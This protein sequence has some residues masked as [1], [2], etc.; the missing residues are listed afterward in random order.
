M[1]EQ[2]WLTLG[3]AAALLDVH[4]GTLSRWALRGRV[5]HKLTIGGQRRF[6]RSAIEALVAEGE[7]PL[8]AS[9]AARA[10]AA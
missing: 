4:P 7:R 10:G 5:P 1:A 8:N 3:K 6:P 2:E 9:G